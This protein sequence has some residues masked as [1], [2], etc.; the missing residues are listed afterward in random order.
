MGFNHDDQDG[1]RQLKCTRLSVLIV[2]VLLVLC[3]A[4]T[5]GNGYYIAEVQWTVGA[6]VTQY[7][8]YKDVSLVTITI[9]LHTEQVF[10]TFR[11]FASDDKCAVRK[12]KV[13]LQRGRYPVISPN[14]ETFPDYFHLHQRQQKEYVVPSSN[15]SVEATLPSPLSGKWYAAAI[16]NHY[17]SDDIRQ[18]GLTKDCTY[19]LS[20]ITVT[21]VVE[22][23]WDLSMDKSHKIHL[24]HDRE[25]LYMFRAPDFT[26]LYD[27]QISGCE[28]TQGNTT[29]AIS[30]CPIS[31][32]LS[33]EVVPSNTSVTV[34]CSVSN[35]S[36]IY[37]MTSPPI[38]EPTYIKFIRNP[39][40][41][42]VKTLSF[43]L[44]F[45]TYEC[46]KPTILVDMGVKN[47]T[48]GIVRY[49]PYRQERPTRKAKCVTSN[50]LGR[51]KI[52]PIDFSGVFV[53]HNYGE[54]P[55]PQN[56]ILL[57]SQW[58]FSTSFNLDEVEDTG[59]TLKISL[60]VLEDRAH[61]IEG[62]RI[63]LCLMKGRVPYKE[64]LLG[65]PDGALMTV[66]T[67]SEENSSAMLYIPYPEAGQWYLSLQTACYNLSHPHKPQGGCYSAPL[68]EFMVSLSPCIEERCGRYGKC[69]EYISGVHIFSSCECYAGWRGYGCTDG[70]H[71]NSDTT[72]LAMTLL[73]SLSNLFFI[74]GIIVALHRRYFVE[75]L[76]YLFNMFFSTFY[77]A[78]DSSKIYILCIM[79]YDTLSYAD[80]M[81]SIMSFWMT[82]MAMSRLHPQLRSLL[83][84]LG[85]LCISVMMDF[86]RHGLWESVLPIG[87]GILIL[88]ISWARVWFKRR[89]C[90]P[91]KWR[92]IKFLLP[93]FLLAGAGLVVF[94]FFETQENYMYTHSV[95]HM[96]M[97]LSILF[98]L[99]PRRPVSKEYE[100]FSLD[101]G[102][103]QIVSRELSANMAD[104]GAINTRESP[105]HLA[106]RS[107]SLDHLVL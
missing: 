65:C 89:T 79:K 14:N 26:V 72:E 34:N 44:H 94:S 18:R 28:T 99:P 74:P 52:A 38:L 13:F 50:S 76:V 35:S 69:K 63:W 2:V 17:S 67:T 31:F 46:D 43:I 27:I 81:G 96:L 85:V 45:M 103:G 102:L 51:Y 73:L 36:C 66:N 59:G 98:L 47:T 97:S 23:V 58:S 57:S 68:V 86:D 21:K 7:S 41:P 10:W 54:L 3:E 39:A 24:S 6:P 101:D 49:S 32:V 93:G 100:S 25:R 60:A 91:S 40:L 30:P 77:H 82:L 80:F 75:A 78:C 83:H 29:Q 48:D 19:S 106:S 20:V 56:Q 16:M 33:N 8:S 22:D 62:Y 12:V 84:M 4:V 64:T 107:G 105:Q 55:I 53:I 11:A 37:P 92:Y 42:E 71:A 104:P 70:S 1:S 95:W 61:L 15:A 88:L 9:P 5:L 90:F 87:G